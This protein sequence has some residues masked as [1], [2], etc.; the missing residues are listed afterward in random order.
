MMNYKKIILMVVLSFLVIIGTNP[1][2][3]YAA[4]SGNNNFVFYLPMG[5]IGA[6]ILAAI[7]H[8][9]DLIRHKN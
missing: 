9:I 7:V 3:T 5:I 2:I 8:A 1:V 6:A 4:S